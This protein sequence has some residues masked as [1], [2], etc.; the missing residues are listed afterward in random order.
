MTSSS[1]ARAEY[2]RRIQQ[3]QT[4]IF[5]SISTVLAVLLLLGLLAWTGVIPMPT[6]EF[7]RP[8]EEVVAPPPCPV[9][10]GAPVELNY[11]ST[12]IYNS[13]NATGLA[14]A[15]GHDLATLGINVIETSNWNDKTVPE[16][17]RMFAGPNGVNAAYTLLA[18]LPEAIIVFDPTNTSE[19]VDVVIGKN[20]TAVNVA[21]TPEDVQA[22]M[23][24]L[25]DCVPVVEEESSSE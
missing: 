15:L 19:I 24:P 4:V 17:I 2:R 20:W 11:I 8:P 7:S 13:T 3:R 5:G 10:D 22:A 23:E 6:R 9:G 16:P 25:P 18:Y 12:R 21:A 1:Q 14:T